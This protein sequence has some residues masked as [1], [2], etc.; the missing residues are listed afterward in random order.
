M[1]VWFFF[2]FHFNC[3]CRWLSIFRSSR[4]HW[5]RLRGS[6]YLYVHVHICIVDKTHNEEIFTFELL[7]E[8][9]CEIILLDETCDFTFVPRFV[10]RKYLKII[11]NWKSVRNKVALYFLQMGRLFAVC[12]LL[13]L[14]WACKSVQC[15]VPHRKD[16]LNNKLHNLESASRI[17]VIWIRTLFIVER[18]RERE[19][20]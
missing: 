8:R 18:E 19:R 10:K 17:F 13:R 16:R 9:S 4:D 7:I 3:I 2:L 5:R 14:R 15:N 11:I 20:V 6:K 12:G 1:W